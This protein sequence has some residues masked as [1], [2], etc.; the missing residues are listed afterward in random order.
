M[1]KKRTIAILVAGCL[2]GAQ[3]GIAAN[4]A[5]VTA[6]DAGYTVPIEQV[7]VIEPA[8]QFVVMDLTPTEAAML[9]DGNQFV[10]VETTPVYIAAADTAYDRAD[11]SVSL[12]VANR[13]VPVQQSYT[14][15]KGHPSSG[16][17]I[18]G[19]SPEHQFNSQQAN[20]NAWGHKAAGAFPMNAPE[21]AGIEA[22]SLEK[23]RLAQSSFNVRL[24]SAAPVQM[25]RTE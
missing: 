25:G 10:I 13:S 4:E 23:E 9:S 6:L 3:A 19:M 18:A 22:Q 7:V 5:E 1:L 15:F 17:E 20:T 24:A 8:E 16:V 12:Q 21:L 14:A 11:R 2:V